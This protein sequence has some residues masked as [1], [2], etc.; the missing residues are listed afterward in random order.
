MLQI[1]SLEG[2]YALLV[3]NSR[4]TPAAYHLPPGATIQLGVVYEV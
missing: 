4:A 3:N 1:L 2:L